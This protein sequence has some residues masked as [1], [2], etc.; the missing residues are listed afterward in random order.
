MTPKDVEQIAHGLIRGYIG[1]DYKVT[2]LRGFFGALVKPL[3][4]AHHQGW[5]D[6]VEEG[7]LKGWAR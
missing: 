3:E 6:C 5:K 4:A 7:K 1:P 2:D